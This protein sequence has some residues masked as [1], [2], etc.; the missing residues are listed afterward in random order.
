MKE[1]GSYR[2]WFPSVCLLVIILSVFILSS[3]EREEKEWIDFTKAYPHS[4]KFNNAE[5][6]YLFLK[7]E[8]ARKQEIC[9]ALFEANDIINIVINHL[10][11]DD[12]I[13]ELDLLLLEEGY[14][15]KIKE[16]NS[17]YAY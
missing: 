1:D 2:D 6:E 11:D 8:N 7:E 14:Y 5:E 12:T 10:E 13:E 3:C 15:D 16:A 9:E 17:K 4:E